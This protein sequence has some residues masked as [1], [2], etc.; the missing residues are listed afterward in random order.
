MQPSFLHRLTLR[1]IEIFL[2]VC[3][4]QSYSRAAEDLALTQPAVSAQIRQVEQVVND[5]LFDYVGKQLLITPAGKLLERAA[6]D[7]QQRLVSLEMELAELK[8]EV[9]GTL[10]IAA[11][12]SAQYFLPSV[13]APFLQQNPAIDV[14]LAFG[15]RAQV[16]KRLAD[17]RNE[18][19]ITGSP[20]ND[21]TYQFAPVRDNPLLAVAAPGHPLTGRQPL[22]FLELMQQTLLLREPGS[23]TRLAIEDYA[24]TRAVKLSRTLQLGSLEAIKSGVMQQLGVSILPSDAC[25]REIAHGE[26]VALT[27]EGFPLRRSWCALNHRRRQLTPVSARFLDH[28]LQHGIGPTTATNQTR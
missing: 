17:N 1:Q 5:T 19:V 15:N 12:T 18:L 26:L 7:L 22:S 24:A 11:E 10:S 13:I 25:Q 21:R 16:L 9:R 23:G 27:V 6:R 8:G 4:L 2:A 3:R 20:P 28:L 14:Q